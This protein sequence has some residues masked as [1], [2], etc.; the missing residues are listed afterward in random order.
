MNLKEIFKSVSKIASRYFIISAKKSDKIVPPSKEIFLHIGHS[1]T[2][3]SSLQRFFRNST[4]ALSKHNVLYPL[5]G[6]IGPNGDAQ[7]HLAFAIN[8]KHPGWVSENNIKNKHQ[9]F[10]QLGGEIEASKCGKIVL[11]S[12]A[13]SSYTNKEDITELK[14]LLTGYKVKI[15]L[16][17]RYP[18]KWMESWYAQ[19]VKDH[20][21]ST[22]TFERFFEKRKLHIYHTAALYAEVFG[23]ENMI[24]NNYESIRNKYG[25]IIT[26][27]CSLIDIPEI[28]KDHEDKN[29]TPCIEIIE[30]LR[31][32]NKEIDLPT[33]KHRKLNQ[34]LIEELSGVIDGKKKHFSSEQLMSVRNQCAD[35][36]QQLESRLFENRINELVGL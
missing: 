14:N 31:K 2:G 13:F 18:D 19:T 6:F 33:N 29:V 34:L 17:L 22:I 10:R 9:L 3:T 11:S 32:L 15:I 24:V 21:F 36:I 16:Y 4:E 23:V 26:H 28:G 25:N 35:Q 8:G 1:K 27:F 5:T 20:P 12:E 30:I 7:H